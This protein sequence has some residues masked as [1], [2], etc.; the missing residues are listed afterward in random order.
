MHHLASGQRFTC[1][2][3]KSSPLHPL[4]GRRTPVSPRHPTGTYPEKDRQGVTVTPGPGRPAGTGSAAWPRGDASSPGME[5]KEKNPP[6]A[7]PP[8]HHH[9]RG[10]PSVPIPADATSPRQ[11]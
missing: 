6:S 11:G 10:L 8:L 2:W 7:R 5:D 3:E 4:W 9:P 1:C